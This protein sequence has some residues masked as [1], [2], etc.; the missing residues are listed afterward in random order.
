ML[1]HNRPT[2]ATIGAG[3][4]LL[5]WITAGHAGPLRVIG[6]VAAVQGEAVVA[7]S[8]ETGSTRVRVPDDVLAHDVIQTDAQSKVKMLFHDDTLLTIG[9][10]TLVEIAEHDSTGLEAGTVTVKLEKGKVRALVGRV[11]AG[12]G[13]LFLVRTP[14]AFAAAQG[15]YFVVWTDGG[16]SGAANIGTGGQVVFNS[17]NRTV[18]LAPGEF[19]VTSRDGAPAQPAALGNV[20]PAAVYQILAGTEFK[21]PLIAESAKDVLRALRGRS[22][23]IV[24][25][26]WQ[27]P[28]AAFTPPAVISGAAALPPP[29]APPVVHSQGSTPV[30]AVPT[31]PPPPPPAAP[32][33]AP[34]PP[35]P[36]P[37][38]TIK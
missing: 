11:Y 9:D 4:V 34:P 20:A 22:P 38:P 25:H 30:A 21:E 6:Q 23:M 28:V 31:S 18:T 26:V 27:P 35:P 33:P 24:P 17:G 3:F 14:T 7:H 12:Q 1:R 10:S 13:S 19:S 2:A 37:P 16:T 29:P 5:T 15:T 8:G 32:R 36:P